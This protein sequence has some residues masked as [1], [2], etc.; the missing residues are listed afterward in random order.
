[1]ADFSCEMNNE[2]I[3]EFG[4]RRISELFRPLSASAVQTSGFSPPA[5]A[6]AKKTLAP[7][8]KLRFRQK[9]YEML[10][11]EVLKSTT[12]TQQ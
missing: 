8:K 10:D 1:M 3:I 7:G 5:P 12:Q 6:P 4:L 9:T 2:R 11:T